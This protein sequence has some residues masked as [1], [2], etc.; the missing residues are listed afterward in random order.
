VVGEGGGGKELE[1]VCKKT[2]NK[3]MKRKQKH[4]KENWMRKE[5]VTREEKLK[6]KVAEGKNGNEG[7]K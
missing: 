7:E 6:K 5:L 1:A 3:S 4:C 2:K